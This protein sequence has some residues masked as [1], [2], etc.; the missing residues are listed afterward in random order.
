[1]SYKHSFA[2]VTD[3][4]THILI[5]GS[6]PGE[7]SLAHG[8]YYAH[9]RNSFWRLMSEVI[10]ENL[11]AMEYAQRLKTL[12]EHRV[13]LWDVI[14]AAQRKGSLDSNIADHTDND[15]VSLL[16]NLPELT[17]IGFNGGTAARLGLKILQQRASRYR[18]VQLPSSSPAHTMS[19]AQKLTQWKRIR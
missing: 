15:L 11:H 19:Y 18:I 17:T 6:L 5:L 7:A 3:A 8:Q 10:G 2:H 9:P 12:L 14:A 4:H 1:M 16:D 13:G